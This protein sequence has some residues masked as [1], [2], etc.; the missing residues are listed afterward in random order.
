MLRTGSHRIPQDH[1]ILTCGRFDTISTAGTLD[2]IDPHAICC[3]PALI[4]YSFASGCYRE[5]LWRLQVVVS[6]LT[7]Y[8]GWFIVSS[9]SLHG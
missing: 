2:G 9:V 4:E 6:W 7:R 5:K 8:T 3:L 1:G